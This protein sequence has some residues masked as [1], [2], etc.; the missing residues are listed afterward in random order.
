VKNNRYNFRV[1]INVCSPG[2]NRDSNIKRKL[3]AFL[4][5]CNIPVVSD[6]EIFESEEDNN[7]FFI[8]PSE[9]IGVLTDEKKKRAVR[10]WKKYCQKN[11]EWIAVKFENVK[12]LIY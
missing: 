9:V 4:A 5:K 1:R 7:V 3:F 2:K 11:P 6:S 10:Y 8:K 12:K